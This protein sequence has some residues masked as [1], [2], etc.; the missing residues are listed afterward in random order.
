LPSWAGA[1]VPFTIRIFDTASW[2]W[3]IAAI[4]PVSEREVEIAT[5]PDKHS[6][7]AVYRKQVKNET[8]QCQQH[9]AAIQVATTFPN[10]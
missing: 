4:A 9:Y 6:E 10:L 8:D 5:F 3:S 2:S 7:N 1:I